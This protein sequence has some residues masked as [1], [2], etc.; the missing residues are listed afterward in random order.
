MKTPLSILALAGI[1]LS[2]CAP[3]SV[4]PSAPKMP[5]DSP[6]QC[7]AAQYQSLVGKNRS[8]LPTPPTGETWRVTCTTCPVT[9]DYRGNRLNVFFN[10]TT[11]VIEE[12]K[13][14]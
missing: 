3:V 5:S 2:A 12:V 14:G 7:K 10:Q 9:M 6:D 13:C 1:A 11:G 8:E 4:E